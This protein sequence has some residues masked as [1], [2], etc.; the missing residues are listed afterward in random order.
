MRGAKTYFPP[1]Y[2]YPSCVSFA[3]FRSIS[4]VLRFVSWPFLNITLRVRF[5]TF[6]RSVRPFSAVILCLHILLLRSRDPFMSTY[7][8]KCPP[9]SSSNPSPP[10]GLDPS[11]GGCHLLLRPQPSSS[12]SCPPPPSSSPPAATSSR[13]SGTSAARRAGGGPEGRGR[14]C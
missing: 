11:A 10:L 4:T 8:L 7:S 3:S 5:R 14:G 1:L 9:P 6:S 12:S 13:S 2:S